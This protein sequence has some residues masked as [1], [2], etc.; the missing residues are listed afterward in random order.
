VPV[1]LSTAESL[2]K[3]VQEQMFP[4]GAH[5]WNIDIDADRNDPVRVRLLLREWEGK[6]RAGLV[7]MLHAV[8]S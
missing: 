4:A 7:G 1:R 8:G 2:A 6:H 5:G 3:S